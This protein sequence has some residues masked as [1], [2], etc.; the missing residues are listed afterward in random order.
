MASYTALRN[1]ME[2]TGDVGMKGAFYSFIKEESDKAKRMTAFTN[3]ISDR[4]QAQ[5]F[6]LMKK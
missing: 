5:K 3:T 1:K 6:D 2:S 4:H